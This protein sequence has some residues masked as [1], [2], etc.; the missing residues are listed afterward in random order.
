MT[1]N[2]LRGSVSALGL[3]AALT[4]G[5]ATASATEGYFQTGYGTIQKAQRRRRRN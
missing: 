5:A 3:V 2:Y 4:F 1:S